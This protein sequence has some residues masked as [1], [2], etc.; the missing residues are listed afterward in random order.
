MFFKKTAARVAQEVRLRLGP[1]RV[2]L[3][4]EGSNF[5]GLQSKGVR[6]IRGNGCLALS[7]DEILFVMWWPRRELRIARDRIT[8]VERTKWHIGK[9]VGRNL[10]KVHFVNDAGAADSA[11]WYVSDLASWQAAL[12]S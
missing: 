5:F 6:Q 11:A 10:L 4:D 3:L 12:S 8:G 7:P 1:G 2:A 9:T